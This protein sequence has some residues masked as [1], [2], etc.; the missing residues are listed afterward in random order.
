[1]DQFD[2]SLALV[3]YLSLALDHYDSSIFYTSLQKPGPTTPQSI[4]YVLEISVCGINFLLVFLIVFKC[5]C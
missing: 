4:Q 5:M 2:L 3:L 1:M